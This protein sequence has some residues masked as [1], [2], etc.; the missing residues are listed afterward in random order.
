MNIGLVAPVKP[1]HPYLD[2]DPAPPFGP[3]ICAFHLGF[4]LIS[5]LSSPK[6]ARSWVKKKMVPP[7]VGPIT[8]GFMFF[9]VL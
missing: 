1:S 2:N 3:T 6:F 7:I 5:Q 8:Y 4:S 9:P